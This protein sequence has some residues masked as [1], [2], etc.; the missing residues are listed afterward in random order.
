MLKIEKGV[1]TPARN[2]SGGPKRVYP[3]SEMSVKDSFKVECPKREFAIVKG[4]IHAA[5]S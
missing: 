1:K 2:H 4:R 5:A 3:F